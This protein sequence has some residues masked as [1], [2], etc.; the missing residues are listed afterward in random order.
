MMFGHKKEEVKVARAPF[1]RIIRIMEILRIQVSV[2]LNLLTA[3]L[4]CS[5]IWFWNRTR[6]PSTPLCTMILQL[7]S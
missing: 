4:L 2:K 7:I 1:L 6:E 5:F 3:I